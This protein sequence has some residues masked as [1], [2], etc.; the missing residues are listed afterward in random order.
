MKLV[1][2]LARELKD[3]DSRAK[4]VAQ[5]KD[6]DCFFWNQLNIKIKPNGQWMHSSGCGIV[7]SDELD[8]ITELATDHATAIVT[9]K[10]WQA[11]REKLTIGKVVGPLKITAADKTVS[12]N[13]D[14]WIRHRGGKCPVEAGVRVDYR[15][16]SS[17]TWADVAGDLRW[18]QSGNEYDIMAYRACDPSVSEA[19]PVESLSLSPECQIAGRSVR[20]DPLQWRDRITQIDADIKFEQERHGSNMACMD[21][22]RADLVAKLAAEGFALIAAVVVPVEDMND[23]LNWVV[24]DRIEVIGNGFDDRHIGEMLTVDSLDHDDIDQP[25]GVMGDD[26]THSWPMFSDDHF[27][28]IKFHSRPT[29]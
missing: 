29:N 21:Q 9:R 20:V 6:T 24:G 28:C 3:W 23:C 25:V 17:E 5:D 15:M 26:G 13:K 27:S 14:G 16:R 2:L 8:L 22:E 4:C 19:R 10:M 18:E 11:E 7:P 1:E 12:A